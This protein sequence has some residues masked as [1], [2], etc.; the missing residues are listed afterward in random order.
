MF[1]GS[2]STETLW[3]GFG[4]LGQALFSA[5]FLIQWIASERDK[6]SHIPVS[7]WYFSIMGGI[8]LLIYAIYREDPV[9]ILGQ[10]AGIFIYSRNLYLIYRYNKKY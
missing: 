2:L 7:F 1:E 3:I 6:C 9:F 8:M 4:L 10:A 5:R